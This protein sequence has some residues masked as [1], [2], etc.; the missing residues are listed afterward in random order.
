MSFQSSHFFPKT[1]LLQ[2]DIH[3]CDWWTEE[4]SIESAVNESDSK[5]DLTS[6]IHFQTKGAFSYL[7]T[8]F[9]SREGIG[10]V[11]EL[12]ALRQATSLDAKRELFEG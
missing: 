7:G 8:L 11:P 1:P 3:E 12:I 6:E 2:E 10:I 9:L 4:S 5:N